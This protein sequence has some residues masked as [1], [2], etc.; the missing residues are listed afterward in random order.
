MTDVSDAV[1]ISKKKLYNILT[2]HNLSNIMRKP[3]YAICEQQ[4]ADQP[5]HLQSLIST[6]VVHCLDSIISKV[7]K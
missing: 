3:V 2:H 6:F 1:T 5:A 4:K 7:A